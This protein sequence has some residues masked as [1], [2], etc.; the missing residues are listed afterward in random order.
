M[1]KI[2]KLTTTVNGKTYERYYNSF[3]AV[4]VYLEALCTDGRFTRLLLEQIPDDSSDRSDQR[5]YAES[6]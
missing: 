3:D 2:L 1:M 5:H 6:H 4:A